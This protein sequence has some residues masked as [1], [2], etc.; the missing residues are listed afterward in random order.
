MDVYKMNER[1]KRLYDVADIKEGF[2]YWYFKLTNLLLNLFEYENVP[3][4][5]TGR[6]LELN[7]I[8][9][10][11]AVVVPKTDGTLFTP[12][13]S[14]FSYDEYYQPVKAVWANPVVMS[15]RTWDIHKD[16]E[17]IY[18]NLLQDSLYYVKA[19]SGL[20][21]FIARYARQLA[22]IESSI[23]I[24]IVNQ[25]MTDYPVAN[26]GAVKESLT[27]F[28]KNLIMGKRAIVTDN[29]IIENF[30]SV[31]I[32][33]GTIKD[34]INDLLIA[35]DKILEEFY[36]DIGVNMHI[37][38]KA[39]MNTEEISSDNQL[40]LISTDSMIKAREEGVERVNNMF[41]TNMKV[42]IN[43]LYKV[44]EEETYAPDSGLSNNNINS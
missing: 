42:H 9:T 26:D 29:S 15:T 22:D 39:Q 8:M 11:H 10:G 41:G 40:L 19:D 17:V 7:L 37:N 4:G 18:N 38:K 36:R 33:R 3:E 21:S 28:F 5:L 24:Y 32:N 23:N 2:D 44:K 12:L 13:A 31:D 16:C 25:R 35:R 34:G 43:P 20:C 14:L 1:I 6:E 27:M 30:R